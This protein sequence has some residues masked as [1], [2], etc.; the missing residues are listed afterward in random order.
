MMCLCAYLIP[1]PRIS[2]NMA[3]YGFK[4]VGQLCEGCYQMIIISHMAYF[5]YIY[6]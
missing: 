4:P 1:I 2:P 3:Q 5:K 6:P